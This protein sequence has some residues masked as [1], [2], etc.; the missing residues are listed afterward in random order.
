MKGHP[1]VGKV[2][3]GGLIWG[4][5]ST[6]KQLPVEV[7]HDCRYN[8]HIEALRLLLRVVFMQPAVLFVRV[9]DL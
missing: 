8:I 4:P 3:G 9:K 5:T 6:S 1:F 7:L 2:E